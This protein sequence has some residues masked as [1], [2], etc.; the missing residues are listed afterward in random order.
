MNLQHKQ[1]WDWIVAE[2]NSWREEN[3]QFKRIPYPPEVLERREV[4]FWMRSLLCDVDDAMKAGDRKGAIR[5]TKL[6][7]LFKDYHD[8][9]KAREPVSGME[10]FAKYAEIMSKY[11]LR[12]SEAFAADLASALSTR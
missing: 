10:V 5:A 12:G 1:A 8:R 4:V 9:L 3:K 6:F 7:Y 11:P 2:F